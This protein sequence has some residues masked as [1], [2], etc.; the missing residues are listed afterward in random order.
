MGIK[1]MV[2]GFAVAGVGV[3]A[4][5]TFL[6]GFLVKQIDAGF[7]AARAH[8][9]FKNPAKPWRANWL[10]ATLEFFEGEL[11]NPGENREIYDAAGAWVESR[12][13]VFAGTGSK[14]AKAFG[15]A[16][17]KLDTKVQEDIKQL[18]AEQAA[19]AN[20][21]SPPAA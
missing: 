8:P 18:V 17:D 21:P 2:E 16:G 7:D 19:A 9:F 5:R 3:W 15:E 11:P 12:A 10:K 1:E 20:P 4:L 13:I 14:W 6:P